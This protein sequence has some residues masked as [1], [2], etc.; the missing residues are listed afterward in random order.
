M[1]IYIDIKRS[2]RDQKC[3]IDQ[4]VDKIIIVIFNDIT[5]KIIVM[6]MKQ[7]FFYLSYLLNITK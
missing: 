6:I 1:Y 2:V 5:D 7:I 4:I 3:V